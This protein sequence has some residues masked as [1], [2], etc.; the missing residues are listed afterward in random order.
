MFIAHTE[1]MSI[2]VQVYEYR[3]LYDLYDVR[4]RHAGDFYPRDKSPAD[5]PMS[6]F[7][8]RTKF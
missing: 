7:V 5:G 3:P 8:I 2:F 1:Y 4:Q 6:I